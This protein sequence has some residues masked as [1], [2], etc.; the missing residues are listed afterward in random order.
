[1]M[2]PT[3]PVT[4]LRAAIADSDWPQASA[5]LDQHQQTL[6]QALT[7]VDLATTDRAPWMDLLLAQ[8]ELLDEMKLAQDAAGDALAQLTQGH[9]GALGWLRELA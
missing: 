4:E 3:L 1:M 6:D 8:R 2:I 5:L 7:G 9:R